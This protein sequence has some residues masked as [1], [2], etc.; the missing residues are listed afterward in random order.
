MEQR[1]KVLISAHACSPDEGSE[2]G[3]GWNWAKQ[4]ARFHDVWVLTRSD[5]RHAIESE[6]TRRPIP[7]LRFIYHDLPRW[8][9]FSKLRTS[10][11]ALYYLMWQLSAVPLCR[12]LHR[13]VGFDVGH[14]VTYGAQRYPSCL[15]WLPCPFVW[16]PVGGAGAG[17][18]PF[19]FYPSFGVWGMI[20]E[21][22][23]DASN[24]AMRIDPAVLSTMKRAKKIIP[25]TE[26]DKRALPEW[27]QA[28]SLVVCPIGMEKPLGVGRRGARQLGQGLSVLYV[29][30]LH[31][32]KGLRLAIR[33]FAEFL[34]RSPYSH[35]TLVGGRGSERRH[36]ERA[37][38]SLG[39][40]AS[41]RFEG[42]LTR[43][44]VLEIYDRHD[45]LLFPS[46]HG[47]AGFVLIEAMSRCLPVICLN[48][49]GAEMI[50]T[51]DV[52]IKVEAQSPAQAIHD[53]ADALERL[54]TNPELRTRLGKAGRRRVAGVFD[55]DLKG[56]LLRDLYPSVARDEHSALQV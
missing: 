1:L 2:G 24:L 16:G 48:L 44:E 54:A 19:A 7:N 28:K 29:G 55:W 20:H 17:R 33:A 46:F 42:Q 34:S 26:E 25:V 27:A 41:I 39:M 8:L 15:A 38:A 3:I 43:E 47:S 30:R 5:N 10:G 56:E 14:H 35:F 31:H 23:R 40:G 6:V 37:A 36:L 13:Q 53:L 11:I 9:R 32:W 51:D 49:G 21:L 22:L 12:H 50:V 18:A 52:G 4:A 45:V